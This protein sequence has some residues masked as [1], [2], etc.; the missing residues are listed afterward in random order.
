MGQDFQTLKRIVAATVEAM[1]YEL[2]GVEFHPRSVSA[3][4]R[5]YIDGENGIT[6]DD[7]QRVSHQVSGVL[8]VE[9]PI[10]GSYTLEISSPGLDRPLF[11]AK[12]FE[13]FAGA[14]VRIQLRELLDGR[15]KLVGCLLGMR[16]GDVVIVDHDGQE[17]QVPLEQIEKARLV[18]QL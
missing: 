14:E 13:R 2:V 11:E 1:G 4:L 15:R 16:G 12:H 3:L 9:D 10:I 6:L 7:C 18:P 5:V 17:W 8:D